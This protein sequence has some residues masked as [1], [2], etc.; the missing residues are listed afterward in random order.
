MLNP[1]FNKKYTVYNLC[2]ACLNCK[3]VIHIR[4]TCYIRIIK[5]YSYTI[6]IFYPFFF[7]VLL[8]IYKNLLGKKYLEAAKV[9]HLKIMRIYS[10]LHWKEVNVVKT[11]INKL[12]NTNIFTSI[13]KYDHLKKGKM[14]EILCKNSE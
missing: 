1:G 5:D 3:R 6:Y 13:Q 14:F 8:K 2:R 4:K 10:L 12:Q 9:L 11:L 7:T